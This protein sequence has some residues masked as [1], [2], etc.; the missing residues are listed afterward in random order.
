MIFRLTPFVK[1]LCVLFLSEFLI[2]QI[3]DHYFFLN[4]FESF[5]FSSSAF[6]SGQPWRILTYPFVHYN[7]TQLFFNLL[8][9]VFLG[10]EIEL[11]LG[12]TRFISLFGVTVLGSGIIATLLQLI[13][14][15]YPCVIFGPE[16][17]YYAIFTVYGLLFS[18]RQL[19]LMMIFP[20]PAGY[21][22]GVM[23][24]IEL[25]SSMSS[26]KGFGATLAQVMGAPIAATLV[27][28]WAYKAKAKQA[29][30]RSNKH[31]KLVSSGLKD[32]FDKDD[33]KPKIWH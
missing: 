31:L 6:L 17:F 23:A 13:P 30:K 18:S 33:S 28:Y 11:T 4:F 22:V 20:I 24:L 29:P 19:W 10:S 8:T 3:C 16:A 1:V 9:L 27:L 12:T 26:P 7:A 5:V 14:L 25:F 21:F 15:F 2:Q 32:P